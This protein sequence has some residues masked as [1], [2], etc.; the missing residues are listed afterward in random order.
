MKTKEL[1]YDLLV[2]NETKGRMK[3]LYEF[4]SDSDELRKVDRLWGL[5]KNFPDELSAGKKYFVLGISSEEKNRLL[6]KSSLS[7]DEMQQLLSVPQIRIEESNNDIV[8][9]WYDKKLEDLKTGLDPEREDLRKQ[10]IETLSSDRLKLLANSF[11]EKKT[12]ED[13]R[14]LLKDMSSKLDGIRNSF[15]E[16]P[17]Q[18]I[19]HKQTVSEKEQNQN[20][21]LDTISAEAEKLFHETM[22]LE[23]AA[24][25]YKNQGLTG[26]DIEVQN[27]LKNCDG[28]QFKLAGLAEQLES[29]IE[30]KEKEQN[31][32]MQV[33][34]LNDH[35]VF[36]EYTSE[37][38]PKNFLQFHEIE[39][40]A[41]GLRGEKPGCKLMVIEIDR[42]KYQ[43]IQG[44]TP[45]VLQKRDLLLKSEGTVT[46]EIEIT[47]VKKEKEEKEIQQKKEKSELDRGIDN[48]AKKEDRNGIDAVVSNVKL[49]AM[50]V[51]GMILRVNSLFKKD[52]KQEEKKSVEDKSEM[53]QIIAVENEDGTLREIKSEQNPSLFL[54]E[55]E[56]RAFADDVIKENGKF[57]LIEIPKSDYPDINNYLT[58]GIMTEEG[59]Q[60]Y[61]EA[62]FQFLKN[63]TEKTS[64]IATSHSKQVEI[65]T[66]FKTSGKE[67]QEIKR[68][69]SHTTKRKNSKRKK[70]L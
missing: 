1:N 38:D 44:V 46:A 62:K 7:M 60:K 6:E 9:S 54:H 22:N 16:D 42:D 67:K 4:V 58:K 57:K 34:V 15:E 27:L 24:V 40:M 66:E 43:A 28:I 47:P 49:W 63:C 2:E 3:I 61:Q 45:E 23:K 33:V 52:E 48:V 13:I 32:K 41:E 30:S 10:M 56:L 11:P 18:K 29:Y 37:T 59:K 35:G 14:N 70:I 64:Y 68:Q 5:D 31:N 26:H 53:L 39:K 8:L 17:S 19:Q 65:K 69:V 36:Y 21:D 20:Q 50:M 25:E 12:V 55:M 51:W